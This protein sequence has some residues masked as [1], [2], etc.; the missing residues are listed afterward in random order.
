MRDVTELKQLKIGGHT[1]SLSWDGD[2][3]GVTLLGMA[4]MVS[5]NKKHIGVSAADGIPHSELEETLL[6]EIIEAIHM[7]CDMGLEHQ[8]IST[9][10]VELYQVLVDNKIFFRGSSAVEHSAF[11]R[12]GAGS[13]PAPGPIFW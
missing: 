12:A 13:N 4:G 11:N 7:S 9:L 6:H 8:T 3:E 5:T 10:A 2:D 1:Y